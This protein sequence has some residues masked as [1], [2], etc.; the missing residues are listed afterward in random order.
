MP[1]GGFDEAIPMSL[2]MD[3]QMNSSFLPPKG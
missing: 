1:Q 2:W 3:S